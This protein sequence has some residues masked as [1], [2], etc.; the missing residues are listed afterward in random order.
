LIF[1]F[2][3][4]KINIMRFVV[5]EHHARRL[6]WDL[7]LEMDGVLKSWAIPKEIPLKKGVKRL[8]IQTEDHSLDYADF[9]GIIPEGF[10]G[11]GEVKIWDKGSYKLI[12]REEG[13]IVFE[14]EGKKMKGKYALIRMKSGKYKGNWILFK[15]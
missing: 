3:L 1:F 12:E 13:K 10:Y 7:R 4:V 11:A 9:E 5:Q 2:L 15:I 8:A 14:V 6:H